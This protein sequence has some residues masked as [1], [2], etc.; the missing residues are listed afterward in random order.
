[1]TVLIKPNWVNHRNR[2]DAGMTCMVTHPK[3][4]VAAT[5]EVLKNKPSRVIIGDAPIQFCNWDQLATEELRRELTAL[6]ASA[7]T[8]VEIVDFRRCIGRKRRFTDEISSDIRPLSEYALFDLGS[9]SLVEPL[10]DPPG[11]FRVANYDPAKL[12]MV[13]QPG[14]HQYL[15]T[16]H[17]FEVDV[18][19]SLPKLKLHKKVGITGALKNL[20]GLNG[21]KDFLPHHRVGGTLEGGDCY[22][23]RSYSR[24]LAEHFRDIANKH[25]G[26]RSYSLWNVLCS[27][28]WALSPRNSEVS[29]DGSWHG[30]DTCWRMCLDLNRILLYGRADG[31]MAE[32]PQRRIH[33][34]TDAIICGEGDSP[35]APEPL[36]VGAVTFGSCSTAVEIANA[37]LLHIDPN[38]IAL[39]RESFG[40]FQWPL[41]RGDVRLRCEGND[42]T[43]DEAA[44][45]LGVDSRPPDGWRGQIESRL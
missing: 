9:Q 35:L 26:R 10:S 33:S 39:I 2:S 37:A 17:A 40:P 44:R 25:I 15:M 22:P 1:M 3:F 43:P 5:K 24:R 23:G 19:L 42:V 11:R 41:I 27:S 28:A 4:V 20:V 14:V 30:N 16:R 45:A 29:L 36:G 12:A 7:D 21:D 31:T 34:L 13:H 8:S 38:K 18:V 6:A 32:V